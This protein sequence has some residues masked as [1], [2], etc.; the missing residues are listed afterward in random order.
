MRE[1]AVVLY[2]V[3]G[4]EPNPRWISLLSVSLSNGLREFV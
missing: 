4:E 2:F 3:S 1:H